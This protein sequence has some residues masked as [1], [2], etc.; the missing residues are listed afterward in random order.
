MAKITIGEWLRNC[1]E[2]SNISID[3]L[4]EGIC[5]HQFLDDFESGLENCSLSFFCILLQRLGYSPDKLEYILPE[6]EYRNECLWGFFMLAVF[7]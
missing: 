1:R 6:Q 7:Q 3:E 2:E 5:T 4:A